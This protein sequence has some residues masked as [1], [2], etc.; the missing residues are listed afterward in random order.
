M[1]YLVETKSTAGNNGSSAQKTTD[2]YLPKAAGGDICE[3][4][5]EVSNSDTFH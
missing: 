2:G 5:S 4:E 1:I 3:G